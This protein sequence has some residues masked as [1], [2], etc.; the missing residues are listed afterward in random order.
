MS[1]CKEISLPEKNTVFSRYPMIC[2]LYLLFHWQG[3]QHSQVQSRWYKIPSDG[4][5]MKDFRAP[6]VWRLTAAA[7]AITLAFLFIEMLCY[8]FGRLHSSCVLWTKIG[9][10]RLELINETFVNDDFSNLFLNFLFIFM[11]K[12]ISSEKF[13]FQ[14]YKNRNL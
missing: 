8:V 5:P 1:L 10:H 13:S 3:E 12:F 7:A 14:S 9:L 2:W 4:V 6:L 11:L